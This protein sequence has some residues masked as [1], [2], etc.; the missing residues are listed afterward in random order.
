MTLTAR[1]TV[2]NDIDAV[3]DRDPSGVTAELGCTAACGQLLRS[4]VVPYCRD[5]HSRLARSKTG[6]AAFRLEW[7]TV[8][9]AKL[10]LHL[11]VPSNRLEWAKTLLME[12]SCAAGEGTVEFA[13]PGWPRGESTDHPFES[14]RLLTQLETCL[15]CSTE[16]HLDAAG[17]MPRALSYGERQHLLLAMILSAGA[18]A[19]SDLSS[20]RRFHEFHR[21]WLIRY[22]VLQGGHGMSKVVELFGI[23]ETHVERMGS[24]KIGDLAARVRGAVARRLHVRWSSQIRILAQTLARRDT[25]R[26]FH[27]DPFASGL[28]FPALFRLLHAVARQLGVALLDEALLHHLVLRALGAVGGLERFSLGPHLDGLPEP[29]ADQ[30]TNTAVAFEQEYRWRQFIGF[31]GAHGEAWLET[32]ARTDRGPGGAISTAMAVLRRGDAAAGGAILARAARHRDVPDSDYPGVI[33]VLNRFYHGAVAYY[34]YQIGDLVGAERELDEAGL[35]IRRAIEA[36]P[37]LLPIAPMMVDIPLQKARIARSRRDWGA[38]AQ[39]LA[40]MRRME[41]GDRPLCTLSDGMVIDYASL[42][43][44]LR[45]VVHGEHQQAAMRRLLD[46]NARL[47]GFRRLTTKLYALPGLVDL[48]SPLAE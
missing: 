31:S 35:A 5:V 10:R 39:H 9:V 16:I 3:H 26:P 20:R 19:F 22:P 43:S 40:A 27:L 21:D 6:G 11:S 44:Y 24:P 17:S 2:F 7:P 12:A 47:R 41:T 25:A 14:G 28:T 38:M 42:G 23:L 34:K 32:Y 13:V 8:D 45:G 4:V 1:E 37:I 15:A 33:H 18:T 29:V 36:N 48:R 30:S 46:A